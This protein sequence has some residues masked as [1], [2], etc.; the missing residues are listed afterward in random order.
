[1]RAALLRSSRR[2]AAHAPA[3]RTVFRIRPPQRTRSTSHPRRSWEDNGNDTAAENVHPPSAAG[4]IVQAEVAARFGDVAHDG[5]SF[6]LPGP[7]NF[8]IMRCMLNLPLSMPR[9]PFKA[10]C[11]IL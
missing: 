9:I 5:E 10:R 6:H 8:F 1:M 3:K 11:I 7:P 2:E 4:E